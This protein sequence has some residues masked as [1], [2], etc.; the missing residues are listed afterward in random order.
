[1]INTEKYVGYMS[2][3]LAFDANT[4]VFAEETTVLPKLIVEGQRASL[5]SA[6][7]IKLNS[8]Q[9][10]DSMVAEDIDKLPD[11][12]VGE[13][14]QRITGVQ[15]ARDRGEAGL[16]TLRGLTQIQTL[17]NG[18][19]VFTAGNGRNLDFNDIPASLISG[20]DVY[21]SSSADQIDGGLAGSINLRTRKP[22][23]FDE[24]TL[25]LSG[26]AIHGD[27]VNET[28]P[29]ISILATDS[30]QLT[31]KG[32][33]GALLHISHQTR[34]FREDQKSA[35]FPDART[36][37]VSGQN[38]IF[39]GG[40]S[41]TVSV[42]ERERTAIDINFQWQPSQRWEFY[43]EGRHAEFITLQES[44]QANVGTSTTFTAGSPVLFPGSN[45]LQSITW[46]NS[47]LSTL[48]FARDVK[49]RLSQVA[50][51][52]SWKGDN[53][54]I[55][56]DLNYSESIN[57][58]FFSGFLLGTT[59]PLFSHDISGFTPNT[60]VE[61]SSFLDP[62]NY[63]FNNLLYREWL[64]QGDQVS[65]TLDGEYW[66]KND[67]I[68]SITSGVR[69]SRRR[70]D[71][72]MGL[73]ID[74]KAVSVAASSRTNYLQTRSYNDFY[75]SVNN[76]QPYLVG[77]ISNARDVLAMRT[78]FGVTDPLKRVNELGQWRIQENTQAAFLIAN[79]DM[80]S[81]PL[82]GNAGL[83]VVRTE[84]TV[85]GFQSIPS[86]NTIAAINNDESYIDVLPSINLRY[87]IKPDWYL[88]GA[89][90]KT[91]RRAD[92]NQLSPSLN[93]VRFPLTPEKNVGSS[94]NPSLE[95]IRSDNVDIAVEHYI[96]EYS[97]VS[98]TAFVKKV[99]GFIVTESKP[100]LHD[101]EIYQVSRPQNSNAADIHG[102]EFSYQQFYDSLPGWMSGLGMQ[103]NYTY[104]D[105]QTPSETLGRDI[106]LANL[107][108][109]SF[110]LI[111]MYEK[112]AI[113][114]RLAYNWRDDYISYIASTGAGA[115]PVYVEDY[116]W[117]DASLRYRSNDQFSVKLEASN[118]LDTKRRSYFGNERR[119]ADVLRN[120]RQFG[121]VFT[122]KM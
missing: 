69:F 59:A 4:E 74:D 35:G 29:H 73:I 54:D 18:R 9:I 95:P 49:D 17:M 50:L 98:L 42:G 99:D 61:G 106:A 40:T 2:L 56:A 32:K 21:K 60:S 31:G 94:G 48:S 82:V 68:E 122:L 66:L 79:I 109:H 24:P 41:E 75:S 89:A 7:Q 92:F 90:S 13:A 39:A 12:S 120:G 57:S 108:K 43:L 51:G 91:L 86:N 34:A 85:D 20:I 26:R 105:S 52:S 118:L 112:D 65:F 77:D 55:N 27:L 47:D 10:V 25:T 76:I 5:M 64:Y 45:D 8:T 14:L 102:L 28:K 87:E 100:E 11:V 104:V 72:A 62:V 93:L 116:D 119:V 103:F 37:I 38:V 71:N 101:G 70:A 23:D 15:T 121:L 80:V 44:Y 36:D 81:L 53:L 113:S 22:L 115:F 114:A 83:R 33:F 107:S 63:T 46:T 1:M 67:Y 84:Q 78:A 117:L 6:Q 110:N 16:V 88:R 111:G 19:E 96:N 3:M 97:A 58:L 30:W